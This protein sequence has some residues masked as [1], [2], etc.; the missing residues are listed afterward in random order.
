MTDDAQPIDFAGQSV[1]VTGGGAGIGR[2]Y[3]LAFAERGA[4]V[5]VNDLDGPGR[6]RAEEVVDAIRAAG[7]EAITSLHSVATRAGGDAIV[8]DALAAYGRIDA[9][10]NN[11][12]VLLDDAFEDLTDTDIDAM[13]AIHLKGAFHLAQPVF[14][15]MKTAGYGRIVFTGSSSG[16]FGHAWHAAYGAAKTGLLGLSNVVA[17]EGSPFG[18]LSNVVMPNAMTALAGNIKQGFRDN[19][20]FMA[21]VERVDFTTLLPALR[22]EYTA[23]LVVY[24]ASR[25]CRSS[26]SVY[27]QAG[28]RYARVIVGEAQGWLSSL[29]APPSPEEIARHWA[30]VEDI[31]TLHLPLTN[32]DELGISIAANRERL[33]Q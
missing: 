17:L 25:A 24:L 22:P 23:P 5:V 27:S 20:D 1:I 31:S 10:I 21:S 7:G 11:A 13:I 15:V 2:A 14:R 33:A 4:K 30:E 3:A 12:G 19:A 28:N 6:A 26:H 16:M 29:D 9:L 8:A 18:I 32:Y